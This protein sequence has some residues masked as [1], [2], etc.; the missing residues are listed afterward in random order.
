MKVQK[1]DAQRLGAWRCGDI[2]CPVGPQ[3][4]PNDELMYKFISTAQ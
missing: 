4:K 2:L 1:G 3:L